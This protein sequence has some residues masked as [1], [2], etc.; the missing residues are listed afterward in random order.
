MSILSRS[1]SIPSSLRGRAISK[2][3]VAL[4]SFIFLT[5]AV[6]VAMGA[7][8]YS[9]FGMPELWPLAILAAMA[10]LSYR[11]REPDVGSR[12]GFSFN[13]IIL[14]AAGVIVGPFGAWF[15][16]TVSM[17]TDRGRLRLQTTFN[18]AMTGIIGAVGALAY[19]AAGGERQLESMHGVLTITHSVGVPILIADVVGC[20]TNAL[21]LAGVI[22]F[23]QGVPFTIMVRRVLSGSGWAYVG[24]GIIGFLFVVLWFPAQLGPF[25]AVLVLAP[26]LAA[27]W[28]FI[29]YG[30]EL[31]SHERT[32]DTLV[33]AL[34]KKEPAAIERS[35]RAARLSEWLAEEL[36]LGPHQ[37]GAVRYAGTLHE[38]GHLA[39]PARTLRRS[40]DLMTSQERR[41]L[42]THGV[43]GARMVEGISFLDEAR[44]GIRHQH[45]RFDGHGGPGS[46]AGADIPVS[47]RIVAVAGELTD[48]TQVG[49]PDRPL[50]PESA[51]GL[52]DADRGRFDPVVLDALRRV[53]AKHEWPPSEGADT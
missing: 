49:L 26:L 36:G 7:Y 53:L 23:Y 11:L 2:R 38:I 50:T 51:V 14:L 30:D 18:V 21:L 46:L 25:S 15:V 32:L 41:L 48:L 43:V 13:S 19:L 9:A 47:A 33:T 40:P 34:G 24:Y 6:S 44:S 45:E 3:S 12:I 16:G 20:L 5:A 22:H 35:R 31:R 1:R 27:R 29:Q 39:I 8:T 10:T 42:T 28:A 4:H 37:I 17:A 52:L